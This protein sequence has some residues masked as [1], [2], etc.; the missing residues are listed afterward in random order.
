MS[1]QF[2]ALE[3]SWYRFLKGHQLLPIPNLVSEYDYENLQF[4]CLIITG[5][6]DSVERN[7]TENIL[8]AYAVH[9]KKPVI[10]ICHGAFAVNDLTG[11]K[12]GYIEGHWEGDHSIF[13]EDG[14]FLVNSYH[15]QCINTIGQNMIPIAYDV[16]GNIEALRHK[17]LEI[18]GVVWHPERMETPVLPKGVKQILG[19]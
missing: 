7:L 13:M 4:D 16:D 11:G 9:R 5:G 2:D 10:G 15:G 18:H 12:N 17:E 8:F 14:E 6:P 1:F 19:M 3:R